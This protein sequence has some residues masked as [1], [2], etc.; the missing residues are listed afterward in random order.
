MG[1][2]RVLMG[3]IFIKGIDNYLNDKN[4]NNE[5]INGYIN[6]NNYRINSFQSW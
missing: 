3:D 2:I 6:R 4:L 1:L 5:K